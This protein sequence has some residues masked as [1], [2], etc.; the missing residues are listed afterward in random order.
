MLLKQLKETEDYYTKNPK[1]HQTN[2]NPEKKK[3]ENPTEK[4]HTKQQQPNNNS[5]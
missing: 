5:T 1:K 3:K 2:K 4:T